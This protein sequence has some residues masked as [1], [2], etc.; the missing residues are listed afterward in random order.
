M[1]AYGESGSLRG[2]AIATEARASRGDGAIPAVLWVPDDD[3]RLLLRVIL[4]L[5]RFPIALELSSAE[6]LR[7]WEPPPLVLFVVDAVSGADRWREELAEALRIRPELRTVVLLPRDREALRRE[8][9]ALGA[10]ATLVRPFAVREFVA[11]VRE[12][13]RGPPAA[14]EG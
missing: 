12:A 14:R 13:L 4:T 7:R 2:A 11:A 10:R 8:A 9:E 6:A 5:Q 1:F 3:V